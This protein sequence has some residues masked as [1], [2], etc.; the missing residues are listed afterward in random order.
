M[1]FVYNSKPSY[2]SNFVMLTTER[3]FVCKMF[4]R[5]REDLMHE[6]FLEKGLDVF[7][8]KASVEREHR[9]LISHDWLFGGA[10]A[11]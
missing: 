3:Q 10:G 5:D 9:P 11:A 4:T 7:G 2:F 6:V 8:K 1:G